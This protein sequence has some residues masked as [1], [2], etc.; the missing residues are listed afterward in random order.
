MAIV[1]ADGQNLPWIDTVGEASFISWFHRM[2]PKGDDTV[3]LFDRGDFFSAHGTDATVVAATTYKTQS[4]LKV[5]GRGKDAIK[6]VTLNANAAKSFLREALTAKQLKVEI[7]GG[8]TSK[9]NSWQLEKQVRNECSRCVLASRRLR[10]FLLSGISRKLAA[11]RRLSLYRR[12][13]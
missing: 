1:F 7:W 9:R 6:S 11:G 5:L 10:V 2:P 8:G 3:R 12:G 13:S 4:V